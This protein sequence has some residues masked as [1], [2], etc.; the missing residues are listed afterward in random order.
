MTTADG[1]RQSSAD[2]PDLAD[3]AV[4]RRGRAGDA[5]AGDMLG[6]LGAGARDRLGP[7]LDDEEARADAGNQHAFVEEFPINAGIN[8]HGVDNRA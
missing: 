2:Q 6:G 8:D 5:G 4:D 1:W 3:E 7:D